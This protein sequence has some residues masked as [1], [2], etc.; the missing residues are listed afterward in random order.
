MN[1]V[2]AGLDHV[3]GGGRSGVEH[4]REERRYVP[5]DGRHARQDIIDASYEVIRE[6]ARSA[7]WEEQGAM[8]VI[9]SRSKRIAAG[10]ASE[11]RVSRILASVAGKRGVSAKVP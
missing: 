5:T 2:G 11:S 8:S 3:E 4:R 10:W 1:W 7:L 9:V 6:G